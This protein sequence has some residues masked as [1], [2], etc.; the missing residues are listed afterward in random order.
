LIQVNNSVV[1]EDNDRSIVISDTSYLGASNNG[2][3]VSGDRNYVE[4]GLGS[5]TVVGTAAKA[6]NNGITLGSGG[7]YAGEYQSGIIQ[8][9]GFGDWTN[10]TTPI[11]MTTDRGLYIT[12]P[13][14][15]VWYM[16][17]MLTVGQ[18]SAGIDGN[19]VIEFNIQ[20]TSSAGVLSVKDAIIV[21]ENLETISGNFELGVDI[22]GLTFAPQ[23]LLKNSTYPQDNIFVGGQIIY[24]Q[25]HYE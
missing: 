7:T 6:I 11:T 19:G 20:M 17:L 16:K 13:D 25:Y 1:K 10:N 24:N 23:L 9:R 21:S 14:D 15:C 4:D 12:M 8:V 5:V 18:I 22:S 2:S 3:F